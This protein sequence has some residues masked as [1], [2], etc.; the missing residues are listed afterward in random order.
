MTA[1]TALSNTSGHTGIVPPKKTPS[2]RAKVATGKTFTILTANPNK[3]AYLFLIVTPA[4][5]VFFDLE[6]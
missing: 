3:R 2:E 4:C 6:Q 5:S 1:L